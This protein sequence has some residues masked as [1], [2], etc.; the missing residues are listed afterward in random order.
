[1]YTTIISCD[2]LARNLGNSDWVLVD[3][4]FGLDDTAAGQKAYEQAHIPSAVYA[5]LDADLSGPPLTDSGRH[6]LPSPERLRAVF[7]RF[8][9]TPQTQVIVYDNM[10]GVFAGRLWWMLR[11]MGHQAVANLDGGWDAWM[12]G[13]YPTIAGTEENEPT[14]FVGEPNRDMLVVVDEVLDQALLID[15][16]DVGRY[17]GENETRDPRGG[18]I[19]GAKNRFFGENW[20]EGKM[21]LSAE[22]L[23]QQFNTLLGDTPSHETTFYCGSGV[24]ACLN[25]LAM[26][27]AGLPMGKL[28]VGSWSEWSQDETRPSS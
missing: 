20:G 8:G 10:A 24:S 14:A 13:G 16:R 17:R 12:A 3:C 21:L 22:T 25:L 7:G 18:H 28:Y 4:R 2:E 27:H 11:Y 9:I 23:R 6:P 19:A 15:S 26:E 5:H 1:M